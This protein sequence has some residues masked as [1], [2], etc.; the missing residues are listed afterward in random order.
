MGGKIELSQGDNWLVVDQGVADG[1]W[2]IEF[3]RADLD[4]G[5]DSH[6]MAH[7]AGDYSACR[8]EKTVGACQHTCILRL[9]YR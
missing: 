2:G 5:I 4:D 7:D 9:S 3:Y 6:G 1:T 8:S